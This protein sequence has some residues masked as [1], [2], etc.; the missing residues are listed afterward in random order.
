MAT[1]LVIEDDPDMAHVLRRNLEAEGHWVSVAL[2]GA[3][4]IDAA[5]TVWPDLIILDLMLPRVDGYT[6]LEQ[7]RRER[8]DVPVLLLTARSQE[9]DKVHGF[10]L[11]ADDYVTKPFGMRELAARVSVL[12]RRERRGAARGNGRG[13]PNDGVV[14]LGPLEV[15]LASREVLCRGVRVSLTPKAYD[16][17]LALASREGTVTREDLM[18]EVWQYEPG[19]ESRTLD[20]HVGELRRKL[21]RDPAA[22]ELVHTVWKVGYRLAHQPRDRNDSMPVE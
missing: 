6:V 2:D 9:D 8:S 19:V 17:L 15:R 13:I 20:A 18:R 1:I 5:H 14:T 11:G 12:L 7:V 3:A 16:L 22:P 4:G 21:E 10:D